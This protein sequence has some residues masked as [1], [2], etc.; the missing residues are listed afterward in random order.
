MNAIEK[1]MRERYFTRAELALHN[2]HDD[3]W[4][5]IFGKVYDVTPLIAKHEGAMS[6]MIVYSNRLQNDRDFTVF[7]M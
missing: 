1:A 2:S 3:A 7:K 4:L 6:S 5:A